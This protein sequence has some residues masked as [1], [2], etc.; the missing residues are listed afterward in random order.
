MTRPLSDNCSPSDSESLSAPDWPDL[1]NRL[2]SALDAE[3][4]HGR[5]RRR[6]IP[7]A[8]AATMPPS[9]DHLPPRLLPLPSLTILS[10]T[11]F[12]PG[13]LFGI[14]ASVRSGR[15]SRPH[16]S[17]SRLNDCHRRPSQLRPASTC[18]PVSPEPW[19]P[20]LS[21]AFADRGLEILTTRNSRA[22]PPMPMPSS[23]SLHSLLRRRSFGTSLSALAIQLRFKPGS[24]PPQ[25]LPP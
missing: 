5:F 20:S 2:T 12:C 11:F 14:T 10:R 19:R 13:A 15:C 9:T 7:C 16:V 6:S 22:H 4:R 1:R 23:K 24:Y 25:I 21:R 17:T 18:S 8:D 3:L